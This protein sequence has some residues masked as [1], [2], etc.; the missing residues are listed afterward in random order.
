MLYR[1][2]FDGINICLLPR[3]SRM[4]FVVYGININSTD[5]TGSESSVVQTELGWTSIQFYNYEG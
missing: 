4:V 2:N 3:E 1:L 5:Q